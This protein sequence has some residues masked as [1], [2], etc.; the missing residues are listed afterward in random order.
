MTPVS[1]VRP[2]SLFE[3]TDEDIRAA[4]ERQPQLVKPVNV[5]V[6]SAGLE[7]D[8]FLDSLRA[9]DAVANVFEISP[10]LIEGERFEAYEPWRWYPRYDEPPDVR[11]E[12]LRLWAAR[13][14]ADLLVFTSTSHRYH[15]QSN[16]LAATYALLVPL[17]FV[18]GRHAELTSSVDVFFFDVRNG[19]LYGSYTDRA[20]FEK[21]FVTLLYSE[22]HLP[23]RQQALV[24]G[25]VPGMAKA[26]R[27]LLANT[28][29]YLDS[30]TATN[31]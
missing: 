22:D 13:A 16:A 15:E 17:F 30:T 14:Q 9:L 19:F 18:P 29:F 4:F 28:A 20:T 3:I 8:G 31:E 26:T 24:D 12:Q 10:T 5:A 11:L 27:D 25:M 21:R 23:E 7:P 6:Y 2:D 1:T